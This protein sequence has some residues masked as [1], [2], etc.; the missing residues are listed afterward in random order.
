[1]SVVSIFFI[2]TSGHVHAKH[3]GTPNITCLFIAEYCSDQS[4]NFSETLKLSSFILAVPNFLTG[5]S[6]PLIYITILEFIS[7]QAPHTMKGLLL[8][9]F[10]AIRGLFIMLGC[11]FI[12]PFNQPKIWKRQDTVFNCGF[13]YYLMNT[14]LAVVCVVVFVA[15]AK[16]YHQREREERPYEHVYAE[17]Y[18]ARLIPSP[19]EAGALEEN[20][21]PKYSQTNNYGA[22]QA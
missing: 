3:N 5:I 19:Q 15:A 10:Y 6:A 14:L 8:G 20:L 16:W 21:I 9:V 2:E 18:Y 17:N 12:I 22:I 4:H 11:V 1:M 13:Y 7:A